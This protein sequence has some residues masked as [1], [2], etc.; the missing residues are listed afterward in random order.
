LRV[1]VVP[2][3]PAGQGSG[4]RKGSSVQLLGMVVA[5]QVQV[6]SLKVGQSPRRYDPA[7]LQPVYALTVTPGGVVGE[8]GEAEGLIDVHHRDHP[9]S[10]NRASNGISLGFTAHYAAMRERFGPHLRDGIAGENILIET[11]HL[12]TADN[13]AGGVI[14]A[15]EDDRRLTLTPVIVAAPCVE[16]TRY[17]L[18]FP[19]DRKPDAT[20]TE[21]LRFLDGGM[22]G[23]YASYN[24]EPAVV[25]I[26]DR[27][28]LA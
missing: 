4:D 14:I 19:D 22:R 28:L 23:F 8:V 6:A 10:K 16:F 3:T 20:V 11:D 15:G 18:R 9:A 17:A 12:L 26:G 24:G 25:R 5:L 7:P 27:L 2:Y 21:A 13:L 1:I